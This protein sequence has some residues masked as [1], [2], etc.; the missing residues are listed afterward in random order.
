MPSTARTSHLS[1]THSPTTALGVRVTR[2]GGLHSSPLSESR[3]EQLKEP[4]SPQENRMSPSHP[5]TPPA[6]QR[7]ARGLPFLPYYCLNHRERNVLPLL[8][9]G[10]LPIPP[11]VWDG[12]AGHR[13]HNGH[14]Q[15]GWVREA[16]N[17]ARSG[18][19]GGSLR[20]ATGSRCF[21]LTPAGA[22]MGL[23]RL[24]C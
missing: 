23:G 14:F 16:Q 21:L 12:A 17:R 8:F 22:Q 2:S 4:R 5:P 24:V 15:H 1:P 7:Q 19:A 13:G 18:E 10:F 11:R 9:F 6:G 3:K 20:G